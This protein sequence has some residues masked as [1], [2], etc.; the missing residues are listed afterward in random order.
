MPPSPTDSKASYCGWPS[1]PT[2]I[3]LSQMWS[4]A[5]PWGRGQEEETPPA[6][7]PADPLP[8]ITSG[9]AVRLKD[10]WP[11]VAGGGQ[12]WAEKAG[13]E[14]SCLFPSGGGGVKMPVPCN[15]PPPPGTFQAIMLWLRFRDGQHLR[16]I[17]CPEL[18]VPIIPT[19]HC[20]GKWAHVQQYD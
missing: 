2:A 15:S 3:Q 12:G 11:D 18:L 6:P 4:E 13:K 5:G 20:S 10:S 14:N 8:L 7:F 1:C 19:S 16:A 9:F 17:S